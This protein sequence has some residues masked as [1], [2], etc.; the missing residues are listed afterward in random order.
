ML[1]GHPRAGKERAQVLGVTGTGW[2]L[3]LVAVSDS[4]PPH[5][6]LC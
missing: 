5:T 6:E 3:G 2:L 4:L 1:Q